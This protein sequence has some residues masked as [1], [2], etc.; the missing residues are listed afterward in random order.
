MED[1]ARRIR[2]ITTLMRAIRKHVCPIYAPHNQEIDTLDGSTHDNDPLKS[3]TAFATLLVRQDEVTAVAVL[4]RKPL[5]LLAVVPLDGE[6]ADLAI[7][8]S[9]ASSFLA[10]RNLR[11]DEPQSN[12][13]IHEADVRNPI[14]YM[15]ATW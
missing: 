2:S 7:N 11:D 10:A 13:P 15:I 12:I 3:L 4:R 6:D 1:P 9:S 14:P 8:F 5:S